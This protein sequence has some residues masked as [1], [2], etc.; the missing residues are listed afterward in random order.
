MPIGQINRE[1]SLSLPQDDVE[2]LS[3]LLMT[4]L[5]RIP[6]VG[7]QVDLDGVAA[8]VT[9]THGPRAFRVRLTLA[10]QSGERPPGK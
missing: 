3:G 1:L 10:P 7:D 2:T 4:R 8:E 6:Q 5:G 9:E